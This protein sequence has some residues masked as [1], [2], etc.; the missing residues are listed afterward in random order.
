MFQYRN[1]HCSCLNL[2]LVVR[3]VDRRNKRGAVG[4]NQETTPVNNSRNEN[5]DNTSN[6]EYMMILT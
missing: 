1:W 3:P 5:T 6:N 4:H 2:A